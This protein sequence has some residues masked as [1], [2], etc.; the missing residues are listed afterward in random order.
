MDYKQTINLPKTDFPMKADLPKKEPLILEAWQRQAI[1]E[2]IMEHTRHCPRY[3]LHDG[4]PYANG[5]IHIGHALNKILKDMIIKYKTLQGF[6][7][8]FI[9]GWDCH[10]LPV[11]LQLFKELKKRKDEVA[12]VEFREKAHDFAMKFVEIQR[13]EFK[14][15]GIFG[16]WD[17]PYLTLSHEYEASIIRAFGAL[18]QNGYVYKGTKPVNWC[19]QCETA[20][21]EAEVEYD[22][23]A[24]PSIFVKFPVK[25]VAGIPAM[26]AVSGNKVFIVIWTTTPW[27]LFGNVACA[28]HPDFTYVLVKTNNEILIMEQ[29]LSGSVLEKAGINDYEIVGQVRG[30]NLE[31]LEYTHPFELRTGK[32]VL[33]DYVSSEDG[34]GVVHTACGYGAE[35]FLTGKRYNLDILMQV[36]GKGRFFETTPLVGGMHV[37]KA[38][39][40]IPEQLIERGLLLWQGTIQH[41]YPHCWRCKE[42]I[43]FRATEQW[44]MNI[45]HEGLRKKILDTIK[46]VAWVPQFGEN[47]I[48]SMVENRPDWCLSRQRLWGVPIPVFYCESCNKAILDH[49]V[50][51]NFAAIVEKEGTNS[52]FKKEAG[53]LL[54]KGFVCPECGRGKFNKEKDILDVW[55]DS[56]VSHQ[57]VVRKNPL[58]QYPA[59]LYLEGSDQHRGW[60]QAALITAMAIEGTAPFKEVLTHGFIVDGEGKK[61][62]KSRG[63]VIAPQEVIGK[64]GADVLRLCIASSDYNDDV[65]MSQEILARV[66]ESYRK[67]RNTLKFILGNLFDFDPDKDALA[68]EELMEI[69]RWALS[70]LHTLISQVERAYDKFIF[71]Q[72]VKL[73]YNFCIVEMS[74]F[75][76]DVLKDRLYTFAP[77][78]RRRRSS[79]TVLYEILMALI[80]IIAPI[81]S[82]TAEEAYGF[83]PGSKPESVFLGQWPRVNEKYVDERLNNT[84]KFLLDVRTCVL[85]VLEEAR[86]AQL[87]GNSL[88]AK[89][90]IRYNPQQQNT[91][92]L[93]TGY[94]EQLPGIFIVSEVELISAID[95]DGLPSYN[96]EILKGKSVLEESQLV[97]SVEKATGKKCVRCWNYSQS[98]GKDEEHPALCKRCVD[99]LK[100]RKEL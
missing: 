29:N 76:L 93:L 44:F 94:E 99:N 12:Q 39:K 9:P 75:Y 11:E 27:T 2:K 77:A 98:V 28:V 15:L 71:H 30:A 90:I 64:L 24:S 84:W 23:H 59:D 49:E 82:F 88:E 100:W 69:D 78:S 89:V 37:F 62:S 63:N 45:E 81:L 92:R 19:C 51:E 25:D 53:E 52:W 17:T 10:G 7:A 5:N 55:F 38:N 22:N 74:S 73:V 18:V 65:R 8:P 48:S 43:I 97:I 87:I 4:P 6:C 60:F 3:V 67:I 40:K 46:S 41:S 14:R 54:P 33:A 95:R 20:L 68:Y 58:L 80:K 21:A 50:I 31:H 96:V 47:R 70:V 56:G 86:S 36:D 16:Y 26:N 57:A 91:A 61:M 66:S 72:A 42:P 32:V 79:Q 1:Y 34:S 13:E 35:D 85:K 83:A